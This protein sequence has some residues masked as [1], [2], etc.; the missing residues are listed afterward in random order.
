MVEKTRSEKIKEH[1]EYFNSIR[2]VGVL[3]AC[4]QGIIKNVSCSV[5]GGKDSLATILWAKNNLPSNVNITGSYVKTPLENIDIE[6][7]IKYISNEIGIEINI[8]QYTPAEAKIQIDK[9]LKVTSET[10]PPFTIRLCEA[11][12]K[13][14]LY[15][16]FNKINDIS[17]IGVRWRESQLRQNATKLFRYH[18]GIFFHPIITWSKLDVFNYI[19]KNRIKLYHGYKYADRLGCS[20][21]PLGLSKNRCM[22]I[23]LIAKMRDTVD[24]DFYNSWYTRMDNYK[25][26]RSGESLVKRL[27]YLKSNWRK[28]K[29]L[30]E[31]PSKIDAMEI[32]TYDPPVYGWYY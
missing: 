29:R 26:D 11:I 18:Y 10:G 27:N 31:D 9:L 19:K 22:Q 3:E 21:C 16:K 4:K 13:E 25:F 14:P 12:L 8:Y 30:L 20:I 32:Q 7:Y 28:L 5:S 23:Y 15:K 24:W 1:L 17:F 6:N 2:K